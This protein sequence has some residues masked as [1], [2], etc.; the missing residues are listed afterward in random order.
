M[1]RWKNSTWTRRARCSA[2]AEMDSGDTGN[3]AV[4]ECREVTKVYKGARAGRKASVRALDNV[5]LC[6]GAGTI[7]GLIGPN[8]A[9][10]T[11]FLSLIAGLL[12]PTAGTIQVCGHPARS[13]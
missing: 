13:L 3:D 1:R 8:G 5:S 11:T 7:L 10:K 12:F 6:V 2:R 9:G 4:I